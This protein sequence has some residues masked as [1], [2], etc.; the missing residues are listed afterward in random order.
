[1]FEVLFTRP[2]ALAH[3]CNGPL[4]EE[5]RR[6]L[7]HCAEQSMA[8]PT[9]EVVAHYLLR[10]AKYLKL[11]KRGNDQ[12]SMAEVEAAAVRWAN[13]QPHPPKWKTRRFA[14]VVFFV[15]PDDGC[16]S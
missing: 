1:M 13:R 12:V 3:H 15:I 11:S 14:S 8:I 4:A 9:L 7:A 2:Y 16:D 6:Y 10:I 5:R